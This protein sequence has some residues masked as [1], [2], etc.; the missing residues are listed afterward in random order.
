MD[1]R[2]RLHGVPL[3]DLRGRLHGV[4]LRTRLVVAMVALFAIVCTVVGVTTVVALRG[5]LEDR[6]DAQLRAAGGRSATALTDPGDLG[7]PHGHPQGPASL[8]APGQPEG[9]VV[10]ATSGGG[11][12]S[13]VLDSAGNGQPL[14]SEVQGTLL[15]VPVDGQPHTVD[16][17]D[18]GGYRVLASRE[19][20]GDMVVTG[21]PL[22]GLESTLLRLSVVIGLVALLGLAAAAVAAAVIVRLALRP[23]RRVAA[24]AQEVARMPLDRGDVAL[25]LRV[26]DVDTDPRTEVGQ[27][28]A[29]LNALLGTVDS[30]LQARQASESKVRRFVADASHELRTPLAAI[31]GYA[32][33]S[34]RTGVPM[35]PDLALVM[36]RIESAADRMTGLVEDLL[37]L[38]R[39]DSGRPLAHD[40]VDLAAVVD[41]AV[42]DARA[43]GPDHAWTA[44]GLTAPLPVLGDEARL[45]QVVANLLANARM[46]TPAGTTVQVTVRRDGDDA[47]VEVVD[48][49]PGVPEELLPILFERFTRGDSSRSRAAGSTGLGLAIVS[50]VVGAHD[51]EVGV[52]SRPGRTVFT[53]RLQPADLGEPALVVGSS[54]RHNEST[55]SLARVVSS[56]PR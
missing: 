13:G 1:L 3:M 37:L 49:G 12:T 38:A 19:P 43:A 26:A 50:G 46:H 24:T 28:G 54:A 11:V 9:T 17:G 30:A 39:L 10:V 40:V 21:L 42:A 36:T 55:A 33:L 14:S 15:A 16:L 52:E 31:R 45:H 41:E 8:Y 27:V 29:S 35:E 5:F 56:A 32:E 23:L 6:L 25:E 34:R 22:A 53:V 44:A 7:R 48:D 18:L 2:G 4:P 20:D 51:G 47:V